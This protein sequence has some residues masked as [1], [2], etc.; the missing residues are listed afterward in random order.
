MNKQLQDFARKTLKEE[1]ALCTED[2][3]RR[4]KQMY[5]GPATGMNL[6]VDINM[7]VDD[8]DVDKL[9][10]AMEQVKKTLDKKGEKE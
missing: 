6:G 5:A 2:Q 7:V 3:Q 9:D 4:F 1:L 10:W 8:M